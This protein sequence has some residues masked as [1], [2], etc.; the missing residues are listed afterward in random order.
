M[1]DLIDKYQSKVD[2]LNE[3]INVTIDT[4]DDKTLE[5]LIQ[6]KENTEE[7]VK[8]LLMYQLGVVIERASK[9]WNK[10]DLDKFESDIHTE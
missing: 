10:I 7:F 1:Q 5:M 6:V 8:D 9:T 2:F 4:V 3:R